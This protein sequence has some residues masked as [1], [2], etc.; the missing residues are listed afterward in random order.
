MELDITRCDDWEYWQTWLEDEN[1]KGF[2]YLGPDGTICTV[3][4]RDAN[5]LVEMRC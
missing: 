4:K 3:F 2:R 1:I 5:H